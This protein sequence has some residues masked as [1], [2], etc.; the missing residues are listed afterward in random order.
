MAAESQYKCLPR[1]RNRKFLGVPCLGQ[2]RRVTS[3]DAAPR[4][5]LTAQS[6]SM[7]LCAAC[8]IKSYNVEFEIGIQ[9]TR[10]FHHTYLVSERENIHILFML[11][12]A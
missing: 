11:Q 2:S 3:C 5:R 12:R 9:E 7:G 4:G 6:R 10:W 8:L 1:L